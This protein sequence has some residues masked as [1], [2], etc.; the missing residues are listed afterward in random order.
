MA[1]SLRAAVPNFENLSTREQALSVVIWLRE[2]GF[3]G[4]RNHSNYRNL[5]NCF[6]GQAIRNPEHETIPI[7]SATIYCAIASRVGIAADPWFS[8]GHVTVCVKPKLDQTLDGDE[9]QEG[10]TASP[11]YLDPWGRDDEVPSDQVLPFMVPVTWYSRGRDTRTHPVE[12]VLRVHNNIQ[13]TNETAE[14]WL[15]QS[16]E[17]MGQLLSGHRK[18]N[19][20][21]ARYASVWASMLL[22]DPHEFAFGN[23][24]PYDK[25]IDLILDHFPEDVVW[26]E[27]Y[28]A[29][30]LNSNPELFPANWKQD[31]DRAV[32]FLRSKSTAEESEENEHSWDAELASG[33][34][35][36][37][38]RNEYIGLIFRAK[39][40]ETLPT[41]GKADFFECQ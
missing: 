41:T 23:L 21:A 37:H 11:M 20:L 14:R 9:V 12:T 17:S 4:V 29:P 30:M 40:P 19:L 26:I 24:L 8:P 35:F 6:I 10:E 34:V 7:T 38:K 2:I 1:R 18:L 33:Q 25:L 39:M 16:D 22:A 5:R 27:Q 13:A 36:R 28:L 32:L 31:L 3:T 15:A